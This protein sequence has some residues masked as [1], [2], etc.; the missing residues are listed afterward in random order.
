MQIDIEN[1]IKLIAQTH[2]NEPL[3]V[4]KEDSDR[5][6]VHVANKLKT[7]LLM[8]ERADAF[9]GIYSKKDDATDIRNA[10]ELVTVSA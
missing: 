4:F 6:S 3:A 5:C 2:A 8:Q 10:I 9:V 7:R 1:L